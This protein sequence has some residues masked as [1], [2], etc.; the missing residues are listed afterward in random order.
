MPPWY[1]TTN[2]SHDGRVQVNLSTHPDDDDVAFFITS[3][4]MIES[5]QH[6]DHHHQHEEDDDKPMEYLHMEN[7]SQTLAKVPNLPVFT[8]FTLTAY[9]VDVTNDIYRSEDIIIETPEGG[10]YNTLW[11][12]LIQGSSVLKSRILLMIINN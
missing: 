1:I 6:D 12:Y 7:A 10:E 5:D 11:H 9:L 2:S 8:N 3:F 4:T